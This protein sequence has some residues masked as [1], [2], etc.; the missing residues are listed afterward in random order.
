M[1]AGNVRKKAVAKAQGRSGKAVPKK[2]SAA[3]KNRNKAL[4]K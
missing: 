2:A 4:P 1:G 3:S